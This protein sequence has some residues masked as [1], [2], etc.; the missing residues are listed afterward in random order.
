MSILRSRAGLWRVLLVGAVIGL[1]TPVRV[2]YDSIG[3]ITSGMSFFSGSFEQ[4]YQWLREPLYPL[5]L[6]V[7]L[8]APLGLPVHLIPV[9]QGVA[10]AGGF[11]LFAATAK[12]MGLLRREEPATYYAFTCLLITGY[13]GAVL[14][15]PLTVL[16]AGAL[17]FCA[18]RLAT[19][20]VD[21][22][23]LVATGVTG[24]LAALLSGI[25]LPAVVL[26]PFAASVVARKRLTWSPFVAAWG[27]TALAMGTWMLIRVVNGQPFGLGGAARLERADTSDWA[28]RIHAFLATFG[29]SPDF[30]DGVNFN[31][32]S[33]SNVALGLNPYFG[34]DTCT[35]TDLV[36]LRTLPDTYAVCG[37]GLAPTL[38]ASLLQPLT[39]FVLL[40]VVV[41]AI[42][43][44]WAWSAT[45]NLRLY[46]FVLVL[47]M[48]PCLPMAI[49]VADGNSRYGLP[50]LALSLVLTVG[51]ASRAYERVRHGLRAEAPD[52][53]PDKAPDEASDEAPL[54]QTQPAD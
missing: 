12:G 43:L 25:F 4:D 29:L 52:K 11:W 46:A 19:A 15:Q 33:Y 18:M 49:V 20:P 23:I 35:H 36:N 44:V 31:V 8:E 34:S 24:A 45:S 54:R 50:V 32:L 40:Q 42:A 9:F 7:L 10:L 5:F 6:R 26:L 39:A 2:Y 14:Q 27:A 41:G 51:M 3:Y 48:I 38:P 21:R 37:S 28:R 22:R 47:T 53:A 13:S 17:A 1:L 16:A 30:Y